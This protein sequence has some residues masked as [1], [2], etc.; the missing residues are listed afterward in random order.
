MMDSNFLGTENRYQLSIF[1]EI[2]NLLYVRLA[3]NLNILSICSVHN[4]KNFLPSQACKQLGYGKA[5]EYFRQG[6]AG[7]F[8]PGLSSQPILLDNLICTGRLFLY[9]KLF[10]LSGHVGVVS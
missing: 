6:Q 9:E 10:Q 1:V 5:I 4:R 8:G 7:G 2:P 3:P